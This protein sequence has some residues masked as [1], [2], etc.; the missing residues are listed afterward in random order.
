M[1]PA[2]V[3]SARCSQMTVG[4]N[5]ISDR[6]WVLVAARRKE[7]IQNAYGVARHECQ[8][9]PTAL[10]ESI[11]RAGA[12]PLLIPIDDERTE[13]ETAQ[14]VTLAR[15][16]VLQGGSDVFP[17]NTKLGGPAVFPRFDLIRDRMEIALLN[18]FVS[19]RKPVLGICRGCQL[20]NF[21][22]GG[23]LAH[24]ADECKP[25]SNP[26]LHN[27]YTHR[28]VLKPG[29]ALANVFGCES[30]YVNSIH[31]QCILTVADGLIEEARSED[32]LIEG[33]SSASK[34]S[35]LMGVQWHPEWRTENELPGAKLFESFV[36]ACVSS[37]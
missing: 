22:F 23:T 36:S 6:P 30:G 2:S 15:G 20:I 25:H 3:D 28:V 19:E 33:I 9:A 13:R 29:G 27:R 16:L 31:E 37:A 35:F 24:V 1:I 4:I 10:L 21:A 26:K 11:R 34:R 8:L 32:G 12:N 5:L 18:A 7:G 17:G 14:L